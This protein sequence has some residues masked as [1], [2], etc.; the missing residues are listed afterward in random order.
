M[1]RDE[2]MYKVIADCVNADYK[3]IRTALFSNPFSSFDD[4]GLD[5]LDLATLAIELE[6]KH[7]KELTELD[8]GMYFNKTT[9]V[10]DF[11]E[12]YS[13]F[14]EQYTNGEWKDGTNKWK[15]W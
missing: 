13:R 11:S 12:F 10:K 7:S 1:I 4:L 9:R 6:K 2:K 8:A 15:L 3:E 5:N 14:T